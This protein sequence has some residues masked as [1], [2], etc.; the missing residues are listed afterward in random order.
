MDKWSSRFTLLA[1]YIILP[2]FAMQIC[3]F[4]AKL[5][6]SFGDI[7]AIR[8]KAVSDK[9]MLKFVFCRSEWCLCAD[10]RRIAATIEFHR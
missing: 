10:L 5:P 7:P 8:P 6:S 4:N 3:A 2:H 1:F 9:M